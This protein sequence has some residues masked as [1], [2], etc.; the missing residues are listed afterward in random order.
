MVML[1]WNIGLLVAFILGDFIYCMTTPYLYLSLNVF[2]FLIFS[3]L[4][5]TPVFL[6]KKGRMVVRRQL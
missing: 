6:A 2:F 5:D 3:R 4:P 1:S